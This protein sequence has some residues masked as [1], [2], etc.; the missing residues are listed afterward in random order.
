MSGQYAD[1]LLNAMVELRPPNITHM[2][3]MIARSFAHDEVRRLVLACPK[4]RSLR[5]SGGPTNAT[6]TAAVVTDTFMTRRRR[7]RIYPDLN[8]TT[9]YSVEHLDED[10]ILM[11]RQCG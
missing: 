5:F 4:L 2:A 10:A 3:L 7:T 1:S 11:I 6:A 8:H 9:S